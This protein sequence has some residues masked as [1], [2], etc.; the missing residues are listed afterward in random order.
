MVSLMI[1]RWY[2]PRRRRPLG[3]IAAGAAAAGLLLLTGC[4]AGKDAATI[5]QRPVADGVAA[6]SGTLG[7]RN[8][9]VLPP[10]SGASY[11]KGS[12]AG[13]Q[14]VIVN[15]GTAPDKLVSVSSPSASSAVLSLTGSPSSSSESGTGSGSGSASSST[16]TSESSSASSSSAASP[17]TGSSAASSSASSSESPSAGTSAGSSSAGGSVPITVPAN[18]SVKIGYG[19]DSPSIELVGLN[20]DLFPAQ[21]VDVTFTFASG[22]TIHAQIPVKLTTGSASAPTV[23]VSPSVAE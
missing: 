14:L 12:E 13:L 10:S 18:N 21:V 6:D 7:I 2:A 15:S 5:E 3:R 20:Q 23:D 17:S 8:A 11:R 16:S 4:A 1:G 19:S 22:A 9:G